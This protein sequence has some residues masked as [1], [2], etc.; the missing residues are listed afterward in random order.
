V[1]LAGS[2]VASA[3]VVINS[4]IQLSVPHQYL[5]VA[6]GLI[7]TFR[8]VGGSVGATIYQ[9]ILSNEL[10]ANLGKNVATALATAGVPLADIPALAG[11]IATGNTTSPALAAASPAALGAGVLALKLTY[12]HAFRIIYLVSI[13]FGVLG[14]VCAAFTRNIGEFLTNKVDVRL[15]EHISLGIHEVHKGGHVLG[16]DGT[17]IAPTSGTAE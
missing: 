8:Y 7:T 12:V 2:A 14:T 6:M 11:A 13:A 10:A 9:T 3:T 17:E 15:D 5:G 1:A 4:I 16:A